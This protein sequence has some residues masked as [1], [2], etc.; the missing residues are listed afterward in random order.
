M[1]LLLIDGSGVFHAAYHATKGNPSFRADGLPT[2]AVS[3]FGERLWSLL[4]EDLRRYQIS[5]AA[6]VFDHPG[7]NWRHKL[8]PSYKSNRPPVSDD[9]AVQHQMAR[10][11]VPH[12]GLKAVEARG[13]EADDV[14]ATY[15]RL[16]RE[17]G[18]ETI[19]C[20][21][22]K[23]FL[24]L[25]G[26]GVSLYDPKKNTLLVESDAVAFFGVKPNR[27]CDVQG[28][29]GDTVD[30]IPGVPGI[31][32]KTAAELITAYGDLETVLANADLIRQPKRR[33]ALIDFADQA[34]VSR[35]LVELDADVP[36][37][38]PLADLEVYP[39][40]APALLSALAALEIVGFARRVAWAFSLRADEAPPCPDMAAFADEMM[41][42]RAA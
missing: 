20:T 2:A 28:L 23:D 35:K 11:I 13:Y 22:D 25:V 10:L 26:P 39:P 38:M 42:W 37:R 40:N 21:V 34:R 4:R 6:V 36:L 18:G 33:Q 32:L 1:S 3:A 8:A 14:I 24:Q 19:I 12:F 5:H 27:I 31:G 41:M 17:T 30:H 15:V 29:A 9:L 7:K 16:N